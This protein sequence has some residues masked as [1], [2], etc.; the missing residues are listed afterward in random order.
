MFNYIDIL[1]TEV[2]TKSYMRGSIPILPEIN[3]GHCFLPKEFSPKGLPFKRDNTNFINNFFVELVTKA[4]TK[5]H[6]DVREM[7]FMHESD[8]SKTQIYELDAL[9][10]IWKEDLLTA[11][12]NFSQL[13]ESKTMIVR[14][15]TLLKRNY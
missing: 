8:S 11:G 2:H 13:V 12:H 5:Y 3:A 9:T 1:F 14:D 4:Y 15:P 10:R 6:D 7:S